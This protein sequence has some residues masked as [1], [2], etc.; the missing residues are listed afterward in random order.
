MKTKACGF[1]LAIR[2]TILLAAISAAALASQTTKLQRETA[3]PLCYCHCA[4]ESGMTHCTKMC[5]LPQYQNRWWA[6]TCHKKNPTASE[7]SSPA[8]N[9]GSKKTNRREQALL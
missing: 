5:E 1:R 4:Y 2:V 7:S 8:S 9:P 6:I 3:T